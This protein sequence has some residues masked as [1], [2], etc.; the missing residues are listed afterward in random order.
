MKLTIELNKAQYLKTDI[1]IAEIHGCTQ[2][3]RISVWNMQKKIEAD[4]KI[5]R[6]QE[7]CRV[8]IAGLVRGSYILAAEDGANRSETAFDIVDSRGDVMRYGFLS[9]FS[10]EESNDDVECMC[11]WHLNA[12]QFYDWMF[13][14]D[15]LVAEEN[16]YQDP[17]G[18][19]TDIQ[20]L[21]SKINACRERGMRPFAYGAVYAATR[22]TFEKHPN[23][24][25]YTSDGEPLIFA[26]WLYYMNISRE[27]GWSDYLIAQYKD[28]VEKLNFQGIH[29]DTYGFPKNVYDADGNPISLAE[30]FGPLIDRAHDA[31]CEGHEENGVI[32]N[33]VNS[34]PVEDV[35]GSKQD[36]V[37]IEV[38]PPHDTYYDLYAL[39]RR[40]RSLSGKNVVLAAY[41]SA[42]KDISS[43]QEYERAEY[44]CLLANAVICASGGTQ[45]VLGEH[46]SVLCDSYYANYAKM[47]DSFLPKVKR[48]CDYL[49]AYSELL[50]HNKGNDVSMTSCGGINEDILFFSEKTEFS[51]DGK[52]GKVWTIV[53]ESKNRL[54]IHFVNLTGNNSMWNEGKN[55]PEII[56]D[57][58][59]RIRYDR[60]LQGIYYASPDSE[61]IQA[62]QLQYDVE[63]TDCGRIFETAVPLLEVFCTIY[64]EM[65]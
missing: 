25:M 8:E 32:F 61:S 9:D 44:S 53:R 49:V 33:A 6:Q 29:M 42:F 16:I 2:A 45:L 57:I 15:K 65:E 1:V 22:E 38:W 47:R 26:D 21:R 13:R 55:A 60:K 40:A 56:D 64:L 43:E 36:N 37:Y 58:R 46:N 27:C 28:A 20:V 52:P 18:R 34:W 7:C 17:M 50:Y 12:V 51:T 3:L 63:Q 39:I 23:W 14:H 59:I 48:Y 31:V 30:K 10:G 19:Q 5:S 62:L 11:Q 54:T 24:G 41:L 4:Y 35:A